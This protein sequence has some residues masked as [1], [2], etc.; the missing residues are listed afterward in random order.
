MASPIE[1]N[2]VL[3]IEI[4]RCNHPV[5]QTGIREIIFRQPGIIE[6][7]WKESV[8][9]VTFESEEHVIN[10]QIQLLQ[11]FNLAQV[12][13]ELLSLY[14]Y[15]QKESRKSSKHKQSPIDCY[16]IIPNKELRFQSF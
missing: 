1:L 16:I 11:D 6:T 3:K 5:D 10:A 14:K 7:E 8:I 4:P 9:Y 12:S 2:R 13:V 15:R